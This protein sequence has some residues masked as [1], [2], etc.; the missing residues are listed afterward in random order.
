MWMFDGAR[1]QHETIKLGGKISPEHKVEPRH[2]ARDLKEA[3]DII[4]KMKYQSAK[5][6]Y[7]L[8]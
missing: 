1:V 8:F 6:R 2:Y 3:V 7:C 5:L 4:I